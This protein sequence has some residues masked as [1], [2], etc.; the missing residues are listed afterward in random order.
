MVEKIELKVLEETHITWESASRCVVKRV[1]ILLIHP[2]RLVPECS[3]ET[4]TS[5]AL[6]NMDWPGYMC[7]GECNWK[8]LV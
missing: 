1:C 2:C 7:F 3:S 4:D 6:N 8:H 5:R